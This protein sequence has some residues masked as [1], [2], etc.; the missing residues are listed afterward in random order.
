MSYLSREATPRPEYKIRQRYDPHTFYF[1]L[2]AEPGIDKPNDNNMVK[3]KLALLLIVLSFVTTTHAQKRVVDNLSPTTEQK[4]VNEKETS[5]KEMQT[6]GGVF[7]NWGFIEKGHI[8]HTGLMFNGFLIEYGDLS[9]EW[10]DLGMKTSG[11][12]LQAGYNY[13]YW[14]GNRLFAQAMAAI[15]YG[16]GSVEYK[17]SSDKQSSGGGILSIAPGVG[18][19]IWNTLSLQVGYRFDFNDFKFDKEHTGDYINI[20][21]QFGF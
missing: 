7:F 6:N 15:G 17:G 3:F 8:Y 20:G 5:T 14:F 18:V 2:T 13:R 9:Q 11:W 19:R 4:E 12:R 1:F 10:K 16:H 21:I